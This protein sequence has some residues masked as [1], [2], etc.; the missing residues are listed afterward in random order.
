[1][2]AKLIMAIIMIPF[3]R[4]VFDCSV[5]ALDLTIRPRMVWLGQPMVD[6]IGFADEIKPHLAEGHAVPVSRLLCELDAV[7]R[8]NGVDFVGYGIKEMFEEFPR[9]F[10]VGFLNELRN[11]E[12]AGSVNGDKEIELAF[13]GPNFGDIDMEIADR[14][15]FELLPFGF[16]AAHIRQSG[17]AM[18]LEAT[19]QRR[20]CQMRDRRL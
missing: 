18:P 2:A 5:H 15:S 17:N 12:L 19:M 4:R 13:F 8:K 9:C 16:V 3:D 14:I 6:T 11:R 10:A 1:M 7:V 20:A